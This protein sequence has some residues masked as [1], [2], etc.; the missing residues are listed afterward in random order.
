MVVVC[1]LRNVVDDLPRELLKDKPGL[2]L[3]RRLMIA[4]SQITFP[5]CR[6][7]VSSANPPADRCL[8]AQPGADHRA[9]PVGRSCVRRRW[10]LL[11]VLRRRDDLCVLPSA[12]D[13]PVTI[14][15]GSRAGST[16][17]LCRKRLYLAD[18]AMRA[19]FSTRLQVSG[20]YF[21][22]RDAPTSCSGEL[23]RVVHCTDR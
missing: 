1:R 9:L 8:E 2:Q 11:Q 21:E 12:I 20:R 5:C 17:W 13:V 18:G 7:A 19:R 22:R 15:L 10:L 3:F 4:A 23:A 16:L 14:M 6:Q